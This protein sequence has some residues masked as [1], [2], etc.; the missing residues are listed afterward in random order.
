MRWIS[1]DEYRSDSL[2]PKAVGLE[3]FDAQEH[4]IPTFNS[5]HLNRRIGVNLDR[6][7]F[8]Y[9]LW[10]AGADKLI[11]ILERYQI[12]ASLSQPML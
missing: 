8:S 2:M 11:Q 4:F 12:T 6:Y 9:G 10:N 1:R 5:F 3:G 7:L